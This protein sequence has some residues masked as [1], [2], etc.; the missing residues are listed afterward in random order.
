MQLNNP[1]NTTTSIQYLSLAFIAISIFTSCKKEEDDHHDSDTTAPVVTMISPVNSNT[2]N[3]GD[4]VRIF[5]KV[6][7]ASLHELLVRIE[8]DTTKMEYFR[9]TPEVHDQ[10]YYEVD[11]YWVNN[12]SSQIKAS[13]IVLAEDHSS[14]IDSAVV[15]ITLNP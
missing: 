14:N 3:K 13:V 5:A 15:K 10:T 2:F 6:S 12:V 1:F 8:N 11:T 7:D 9:L 4:T